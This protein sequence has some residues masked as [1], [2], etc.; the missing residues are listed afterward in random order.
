MAIDYF[1]QQFGEDTY[2]DTGYYADLYD[3]F[4]GKDATFDLID[5]IRSMGLDQAAIDTVLAPYRPETSS[6]STG[7]LSQATAGVD[8]SSINTSNV[9]GTNTVS[10]SGNTD[11]TNTGA[12]SQVSSTADTSSANTAVDTSSTTGNNQ[13]SGVILA[14]DSWLAGDD[15]TNIANTAFDTNVTNTAIGGQTTADV[16]NQLNIFERDGGTFAPGSTVVLSIGGNDLA[17]G[18]DRST[19]TSN[20]N[21]IVSRLGDYGVNVILSAAPNADSYD[22]AISSTNLVMDDLYNQ[23]AANN[24]NVT[25]VDVMSGMLNDKTL[26]DASGFHLKDEA[27]KTA[28]IGKLED[29]YNNLTPLQQLA[30]S[31]KVAVTGE[32]NPVVLAKAIDEVAGT[33]LAAASNQT[34]PGALAQAD[35]GAVDLSKATNLNNGTYLTSAGKI[36]DT[37][38][39]LVKDTGSSVT[40]TLTSQILGQN[41]TDKWQGEGKGSAQANA[42]DMA[43]ILASIDITDIN[44]FGVVPVYAPVQEI[45][46]F[47]NGQYVAKHDL[48]DGVIRNVI[49]QGT[50]QIDQDGNEIRKLVEVPQGAA[51]TTQYGRDNGNGELEAIDSSKLQIVDGK[52]VVDTGQTTFGNKKT[53]EAVPNTY[54]ERQTGNAFGGTFDGSG[55]TGYRVQFTPDGKPIFYTTHASSSDIG[56]LAPLLAIA[57]F[58][59]G[60]APFAQAINAAIAIDNG[61]VLGGLA[62][63]A[64]A[65][66]FT[67]VA[68][69]LRVASAVDQGNLGALASSL[70]QNPTVGALAGSTMLTDTISLADAGNAFNVVTNIDAGNYAGALN[71]LGTLTNSSDLKTAGAAVNLVNAL[72]SGNE[73]NIINAAAGL[74]NT[75]NAANNLSNATVAKTITT[76]VSD[77]ADAFVAAKTAGA[78]D[79]EAL[80]AANT[81]TGTG[82]GL[83][84]NTAVSTTTNTQTT[85]NTVTGGAGNDSVVTGPAGTTGN[86]DL[87]DFKG[88]DQAIDQQSRNTEVDRLVTAYEKTTGKSFAKLTDQEV[89]ALAFTANSMTTDQLKNASIQDI[90]SKAPA[91]VGKD[92]QGRWVDDK[93]FAYDERGLK[94]APGSTV[95]MIDIAGVGDRGTPTA[96]QNLDTAGNNLVNWANTLEG[97][98]GDV[99]RQTLSTLIGA[100]GEQ[101]ADLGTALAN[102]GMAER[103]NV[104][105]QLGQSLE[106]TGQKLEIPGVTQATNNFINDIQGAD[107]YAGKAAA[108]I[109]SVFNNPLVLTQVAK[110]GLQ[111]VLPIVTGGAVFKILGKTAGIATD[112]IMN[113]SESMGSQSRQKFNEEIAKG[114]PVDQ[115]ERLANADGWKA[116]AITAGTATLADAALIKGYERAMDKVFGKTTTSV[117]KEWAEEGFEE[118]AVALATGDD[119]ATAMTKSIA[120]STIG[121]KT[122]GS[123]TAGSNVSADI[124]QAFAS[125]G[126]TSTDGTFRPETITKITDTGTSGAGTQTAVTNVAGSG[127]TATG[128]D[129]AAVTNTA[130]TGADTAAATDFASIFT[131]TGNT[132]QAVDTSVGTAI[133]GGADVNNT[134]ASVVNAANVTGANANVVAA[135]ATNAAVAAG[136]DVATASNAATTAVS[137]VTAGTGTTT[138]GTGTAATTGTGVTTGTATGANTTATTGTTTSTNA[139][140]GTTTSSNAATG[141]TSSTTSDANTGT[142]TTTT[143]NATT[144]TTTAVSTNNTTGITTT[145]NNNATT[146]VG[147]TSTNNATTGVTTNTVVGTNTDLTT[148]LNVNTDTGE[149][150]SVDGPGKVIDSNTVVVD[151]TAIDVTTGETLTPEEVNKRIEAAKTKLATPKKQPDLL[152]G[153]AFNAPTYKAKDSDI[154]ET[155]LG[156]RFRN[157]APLAGL[158]ALLPQDTPMFQEAQALSALRRASGVEDGAE[159]PE[160]DYYAYGTEPSYSKVLEPFMNGGTVQKYADG[161]KIMSSPLMAA[162]GGDVPHKGSH[163]VQGAGGG[164]DDLISAKLADGEYVFDAD[165]VAALGDGSNKEGAKRLDAMREAIRKH[166]RGGSIKSIPPAAKSPLA[167]LKGAL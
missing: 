86:F 136:A 38:G 158:G 19:I 69:G 82:T 45:G 44:D 58:I 91:I 127:T 89:A 140:T 6:A 129:T 105:V 125:E 72:N 78:T 122:S 71:S 30:V 155:W 133:S 162:L 153:V 13:L 80:I 118:L 41:L 165:I 7:A 102:M 98:S 20:L 160:A 167:Y 132:T 8:T 145:T 47:Y 108:A 39:N 62:S 63:L 94:Y 92:D 159:K 123:L 23:V 164:Q 51:L 121:S 84:T 119:L 111:E 53:G 68:T 154:A 14:G 55:N 110:E 124:Q 139:A 16:L 73:V 100:G 46:Q 32:S 79:E 146:G 152:A 85:N 61:D 135:T 2:E 143:S 56:D 5:T 75:I 12:L 149:I 26:M 3:V 15:F 161:G 50:G 35:T 31:N 10:Q 151:G 126:L 114:T 48:G 49:Y 34:A 141:V 131:T 156:G 27:S 103:Y 18:V 22:E 128:A 11:S 157:I 137:N 67:D 95:P 96:A 112:V 147:T 24:S 116:F 81:V 25:L 93:G 144:G 106:G 33:N 83:N 76:T 37:E 9:S 117:G 52:P 87:G 42:A 21:E 29:A 64:G 74:N 77:G 166:K 163:Y 97:T 148:T 107:T 1:A 115:A 109:K 120:G 36:V 70:L 17:T 60:V 54:S 88:V 90:L 59:P 57:S 113:A 130:A 40:A 4:G 104:L 99:V 150:I 28:Y 43:G 134:I 66:G 142:T 101:V 65:G 138:A